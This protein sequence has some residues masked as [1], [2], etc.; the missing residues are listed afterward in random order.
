MKNGLS[1]LETALE[2]LRLG[3]WPVVLH[4]LGSTIQ[5]AEGPKIS[6]GKEPIGQA[7]G[8]TQPTEQSLRETFRAYPGAGVGLKLGPDGNVFDIE[9]DGP[10]GTDSLMKLMGKENAATIGW[11]SRR[12]PHLLFAWDERITEA[13]NGKSIVKLPDFPGLEFRIGGNGKQIQSACP[14]TLGEDSSPRVWTGASAI[15]EAPDTVVKALATALEPRKESPGVTY[16]ARSP[17]PANYDETLADDALKALGPVYYDDYHEWI[18]IG[19]ALYQLGAAGLALWTDW[20]RNSQKYSPG[21]CEAKWKTFQEGAVKLG[22]L[23]HEAERNG[24]RRPYIAR[25]LTTPSVGNRS[26]TGG[27]DEGGDC[28]PD[29][30]LDAELANRPC[31]D[32]GNAERLVARHG[33]DMRHCGKWKTWLVWD[34]RRW[35]RD[36]TSE[37]RSRTR[38]TVR[39]II[40]E[41]AT[42]ADDE[43]RKQLAKW[44]IA[45]EKRDRIAAMMFLAEAE[46]GMPVDPE[47]LDTNPWVFNCMK[48]TIDLR[49]GRL[50]PHSRDDLITKLCPVEYQPDAQCPLWLATLEKFF[51]RDDKDDQHDLI[52]Y[53]QRLCGYALAGEIRDHV[54]PVAYG[55]GNNGKST[56]LGALLDTFGPDYAMKAMPDLFMMKRGDSH[57]TQWADLFGKRLVMV[58][59]TEAGRRLNEVMVKEATGGDRIRARWMHENSFEFKPSHTIIMATNHKPVIKGTDKG[60]WRRIKLVPFTVSVADSEADP[61]VPTRLRAEFP[62]ILAWCVRGCHKWQ[63]KALD[64]PPEV[65][66]ATDEYRNDE[67]VLGAFIKECCEEKSR[68]EIQSSVLYSEYSHWSSRMGEHAMSQTAFGKA[69]K[70]RGFE[71]IKKSCNWYKGIDL[72]PV[73]YDSK[74]ERIY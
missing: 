62:G 15:A 44:A 71:T 37:V 1:S 26:P 13:V 3:L 12:G 33:F 61:T 2:L 7:W 10:E 18:K 17:T 39:L 68:L 25:G 40:N 8:E 72:K 59:E 43:H 6:K 60:I 63:Q 42:A 50:L 65:I 34:G 28:D 30:S 38:D 20:S 74:G 55:T 14:P 5:T 66:M 49:T 54:M 57:P 27:D 41:A 24:W 19:M 73:S 11:K 70:E 51:A 4:P 36:S 22:T 16:T 48:V 35:K 52:D 32:L 53:W 64:P 69:I 56:I 29:P 58:I 9:V 21:V 23:F 67:D 46:R 45:S 31:T 47:N